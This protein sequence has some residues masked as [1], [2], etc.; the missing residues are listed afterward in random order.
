MKHVYALYKN[1]VGEFG[2]VTPT[3]LP[4]YKQTDGFNCRPFASAYVAEILDGKSPT[5]AVFGV[6]KMRRHLILSLEQQELNHFRNYEEAEELF[7]EM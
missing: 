4:V 3:F 2:K 7:F 5:E 6:Y 1:V